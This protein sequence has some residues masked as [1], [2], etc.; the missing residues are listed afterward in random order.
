MTASGLESPPPTDFSSA[1]T[2]S[3]GT[4]NWYSVPPAGALVILTKPMLAR[5]QGHGQRD[6]EG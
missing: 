1:S 2:L 6:A 5:A 4:A 3:A